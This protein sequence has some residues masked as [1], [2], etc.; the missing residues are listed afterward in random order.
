MDQ[1]ENVCELEG[2]T[3]EIIQSEKNKEKDSKR[4]KKAHMI[5]EIPSKETICTLL[6]S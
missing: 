5:Y 3:F 6:E 2:R 4:G 1:P